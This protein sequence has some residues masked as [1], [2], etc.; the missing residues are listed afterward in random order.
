MN[1]WKMAASF[2]FHRGYVEEHV[3]QHRLATADTTVNIEAFDRRS[4]PAFLA[5][6]Q[7]RA[8]FFLA[9]LR[10]FKSVRMRSRI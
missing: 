5:N 3:H 10:I 2:L 4:W 1:S 9:G 6:I 7:P 8:L